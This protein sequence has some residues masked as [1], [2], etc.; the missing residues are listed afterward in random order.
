LLCLL[1]GV[2]PDGVGA[3]VDEGSDGQ[4]GPSAFVTNLVS[5][6]FSN[7]HSF[8]SMSFFGQQLQ[9]HFEYF[10][11][12]QSSN[13]TDTNQADATA[14]ANTTA[15]IFAGLAGL[16]ISMALNCTQ[17]LNWSVRMAS[18]LESQMVSVE[19]VRHCVSSLALYLIIW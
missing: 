3:T 13:I 16:A 14:D 5:N 7:S 2:N 18:D 6:I 15:Q 4:L 10:S 8:S 1:T 11:T 19:R 17:S 12:L 9:P